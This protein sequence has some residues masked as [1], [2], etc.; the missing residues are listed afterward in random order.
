MRER[1]D[2]V[3][4]S[5]ALAEMLA[6]QGLEIARISRPKQT[7]TTQRWKIELKAAG[8]SLPLHTRV[9]CKPCK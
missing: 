9:E 2:K 5:R 1:F 3:L 7:D 6:T 4:A 8:V